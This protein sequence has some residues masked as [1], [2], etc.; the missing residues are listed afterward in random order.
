MT[1]MNPITQPQIDQLLAL[2]RQCYPDWQNFNHPRFMVEEVDYK[3]QA[4]GLLRTHL[5]RTEFERLLRLQLYD[6]IVNR[7][8]KVAHAT[9]LLYLSTPQSGDLRILYATTIDRGEL[10][11]QLFTLLYGNAAIEVRFQHYLDFVGP[12]SSLNYW[13]FPTYFLFLAHPDRE[14]F[15]K[16]SVVQRYLP[17]FGLADLWR[18]NPN[19]ATYVKLVTLAQQI[20]RALSPYGPHDLIDIQGLLWVAAKEQEKQLL[21][22][23]RRTEFADLFRIFLDVYPKSRKGEFH[24]A[25][26][27]TGRVEAKRNYAAIMADYQSGQDV[28]NRVLFQ[29]L[30][31]PS[32]KHNRDSAVQ[33]HTGLTVNI[34]LR[35]WYEAGG[36]TNPGDWPAIAQAILTF[37]AH[38]L[39]DSAALADA[40]RTFSALPYSQ[41]FKMGQ[42][43]P[44]LNALQPAAFVLIN[45]KS[46]QVLNYFTGAHHGQALTN[47]P[48]ANQAMHQLHQELGD[49]LASSTLNLSPADTFDMFCHWLVAV[50]KHNFTPVQYWK[51]SPGENGWQW[52]ECQGGNFIAIGWDEL[53]DLTGVSRADF[54]QRRDAL[55]AQHSDWSKVAVNQVWSFAKQIKEGDR[56]VANRGT[57]ELL[58]TGTVTGPYYF[59]PEVRHGHRLPVEWDDITLR[60]IEQGGWRKTLIQL[61]HPTFDAVVA[62]APLPMAEPVLAAP[63]SAIFTTK[64]DAR[65]AFDLIAAA[66]AKLGITSPDDERFVVTLPTEER[67]LHFSVGNW[68]VLGFQRDQLRLPLLQGTPIDDQYHDYTFTQLPDEPKVIGYRLPY[69]MLRPFPAAWQAGYDGALAHIAQRVSTYVRSPWR[70]N[71]HIAAL[72][73][74]LF[75]PILREDL[76]LNG[77]PTLPTVSTTVMASEPSSAAPSTPD[78][79]DPVPGCPF[80]RTTFDLLAQLHATPTT[81]FYLAHKEDFARHVE[82]PF[83]W[84][85]LEV[86]RRLPTPIRQRMETERRLFARFPKNDWGQ[87]GAWDFYWGAFHPKG[88]KRAQDAQL[89]LWMNY[90]FL[91]FGFYIG[92][93]GS[94]QRL[95]FQRNCE[96]HVGPL[97]DIMSKQFQ[98]GELVLGSR[99][100]FTVTA[101]GEVI[102]NTRRTWSDFIRNP[103]AANCDASLIIPAATLL[104]L[105]FEELVQRVL[106]G[107]QR[108]FPLVLAAIEDD[109][110]PAIAAY[111]ESPQPDADEDEN[112]T[113]PSAGD[114]P[115]LPYTQ[116]DFLRETHLLPAEMTDLLELLADKRQL[117]L[118]GPPG[119]G[120]TYVA[121]RL[122]KLLTGLDQ[123]G[124][125]LTTV[126]F[127]PA[128]SYEDF[129]EGIRP[130]SRTTVTGQQVVDYPVRP[131]HFLKFC[132]HAA[133]DT[134]NRPYIFIIDEI[135]RGNIAR[136]FGELMYLL[137]YRNESVTLP[138]SGEPFRI[139][140]N[141]YLIGTMNTADRSVALVDFALRRRFHFV[142]MAADPDLFDR[143]LTA[144]T[145]EIP[146]LS[147][148]YRRLCQE[149]IDDPAY[150]IGPSYF[151]QP[152]LTEAKLARIWRYSIEP[153]LNEYYAENPKQ[154]AAWRWDS[155]LVQTMRRGDSH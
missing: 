147:A 95:R 77:L 2:V 140:P 15:V 113:S 100:D 46:C 131:G 73:A 70:K 103:A 115:P 43:T 148:L 66:L 61:D 13:T 11:R 124:P 81:A 6:E 53:G 149:A 107:H 155:P 125:C 62:G 90:R 65:W 139:P 134:T 120:K 58:G 136:I 82:E 14:L 141:L 83:K 41:A 130:D 122:A 55:L 35:K 63:F 111:L 5:S 74:A 67:A 137:E 99:D 85:L 89:S 3:Q 9:N 4:A 116:S 106:H 44:I 12:E 117:I 52:A 118:Q 104:T 92:N 19:V 105:T 109:P 40:C 22:P 38:C 78:L 94:E 71:H 49:L 84:L 154:A 142:T 144:H 34:D 72:A 7:L 59:V 96:R 69:A 152:T 26:Y 79:P 87:G 10:C 17:W 42:M 151:I 20:Q 27:Q 80:S 25:A 146:Y 112:I 56:I 8:E 28:T 47:Y 143:W 54:D 23:E 114:L 153:L 60:K 30:P 108:L 91:E 145:V 127:H 102:D 123:P 50:K 132:A 39:A 128:Y 101:E 57:S 88:S 21:T 126:Q 68:L 33:I 51:I 119:T 36:W 138:Y 135:N 86:G 150:R 133:R 31:Y 110:M 16:P 98:P 29:L 48:V 24:M 1:T 121:Q 32:T 93:Y 75:D 64:A 37:I 45:N 18:A 129:M 76:L 97:S